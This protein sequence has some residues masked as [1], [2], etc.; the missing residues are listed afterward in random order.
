MPE[1]LEPNVP[2]HSLKFAS[3]ALVVTFGGSVGTVHFYGT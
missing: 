2:P 3:D 1:L